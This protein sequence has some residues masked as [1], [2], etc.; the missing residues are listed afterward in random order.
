MSDPA[1]DRDEVE[2]RL[3][4]VLGRYAD[5]LDADQV[6]DL[7]RTL[8]ALVEQVTALRAVTLSNSDGPLPRFV[9]FRAG[10]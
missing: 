4:I 5:R 8:E 10:E 9:P 6:Q 1:H 3:A 7:H 2:R